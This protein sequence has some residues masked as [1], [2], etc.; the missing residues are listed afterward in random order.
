MSSVHL[1]GVA[2]GQCVLLR[3]CA[4]VSTNAILSA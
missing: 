1:V 2:T 3:P 4:M